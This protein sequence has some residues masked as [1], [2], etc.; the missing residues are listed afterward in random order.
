MSSFLPAR[1]TTFSGEAWPDAVWRFI[2]RPIAVGGMLVGACFTLFR[3][4]KSLAIGMK[5]AVS[6]LKKSAVAQAVTNRT[7][8]DLNAKAVFAGLF[9]VLLCMIALYATLRD[10][11]AQE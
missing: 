8:L 2:V 5:R 1:A 7:E 9:A 6:D 10:R 4:R 11:S 3:M